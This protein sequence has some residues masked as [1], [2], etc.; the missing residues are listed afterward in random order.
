MSTKRSIILRG[1]PEINE[2]GKATE[3]IKPGYLVKGVSYLANQSATTTSIPR[4]VALERD[5]LGEGI[6]NTLQ[7]SGTGTAFYASGDQ[8]KV[9]AFDGG[10]EATLFLASGEVCSEDTLLECNGS[11]AVKPGTTKP[12]ARAMEAITVAVTAQAVRVQFI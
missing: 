11:G 5:E 4:S 8:V 12:V 3:Q 1:D 2:Y 10:D 7:G 6:D 9:A